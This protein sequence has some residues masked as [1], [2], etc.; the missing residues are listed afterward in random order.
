M[1]RPALQ[2]AS[3]SPVREARGGGAGGGGSGA[4]GD[5]WPLQ[6]AVV[7]SHTAAAPLR[8]RARLGFAGDGDEVDVYTWTHDTGVDWTNAAP[9]PLPNDGVILVAWVG[10]EGKWV[11]TGPTMRGCA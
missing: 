10:R 2:P 11:L 6:F 7:T 8:L 1:R 5:G 3:Y 9:Y 4:P